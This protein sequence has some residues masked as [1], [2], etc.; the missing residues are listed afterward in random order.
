MNVIHNEDIMNDDKT[1]QIS[2]DETIRRESGE[3]LIKMT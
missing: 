2:L 3:T 1:P